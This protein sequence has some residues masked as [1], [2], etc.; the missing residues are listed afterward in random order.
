MRK[1]IIILFAASVL[2]LAQEK[3]KVKNEVSDDVQQCIDKIAYN[4]PAIKMLMKKIMNDADFRKEIHQE[5]ID[6]PEINKMWNQMR[7]E[8]QHM[9]NNKKKE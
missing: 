9:M 6:D 7:K 2:S 4:K 1:L 3:S 5:L 8:H